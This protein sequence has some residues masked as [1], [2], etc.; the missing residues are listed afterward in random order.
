MNVGEFESPPDMILTTGDY[1]TKRE[2]WRRMY[3]AGKAD[4]EGALHGEKGS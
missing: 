1:G 3:P 4:G 2:L